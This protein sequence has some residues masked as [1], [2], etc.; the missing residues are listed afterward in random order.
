MVRGEVV[1]GEDAS[2]CTMSDIVK[3][4]PRRVDRDPSESFRKPTLSLLFS[5]KE[6]FKRTFP[7]SYLP[8]IIQYHWVFGE[9]QKQGEDSA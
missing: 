1:V 8:A 5:L 9:R 3:R 4:K 7:M 6:T 2:K